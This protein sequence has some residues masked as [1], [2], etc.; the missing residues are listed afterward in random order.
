MCQV[1]GFRASKDR[2]L[3]EGQIVFSQITDHLPLQAFQRCLQR[4]RW[5]YKVKSFSCLDQFLC[6]AFARITDRDSL[7]DIETGLRAQRRKRYHMGIRGHVARTTSAKG[8][9]RRDRRIDAD[10]ARSLLAI[11]RRRDDRLVEPGAF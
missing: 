7:R 10:R 11:A 5:P 1:R 2:P 8:N 3:N 4:Y 6:M 9:E